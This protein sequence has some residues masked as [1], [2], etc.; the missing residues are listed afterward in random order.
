MRRLLPV[1]ADI[2]LNTLFFERGFYTVITNEC[3]SYSSNDAG[4]QVI[5]ST[6][7]KPRSVISEAIGNQDKK[8]K[9]TRLFSHL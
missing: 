3:Q 1:K 5:E 7:G 2:F 6:N 9:G 4:H 8:Y